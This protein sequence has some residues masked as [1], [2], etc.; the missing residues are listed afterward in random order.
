[1]SLFPQHSCKKRV[2]TSFF[3]LCL[4]MLFPFLSTANASAVDVDISLYSKA[5]FLAKSGRYKQAAEQYHRLSIMFLSSEAKLGRKNMWQYAGLAEGLA[6]IAADKSNSAKAYQYWADSMRY[7]M[8]GGT[9]WDQMKH[10]LHMRYEAANTQLSTQLQINDFAATI[11]EHWQN[12][13]D[14]LQ[15][16]D[17]KL[18]FFSFSSPKLG[19]VDRSQAGSTAVNASQVKPKVM[20]QPP[21]SSGKKLSGLNNSFSQSKQFAPV[22]AADPTPEPLSEPEPAE[23]NEPTLAE[24]LN[25]QKVAPPV[26]QNKVGGSQLAAS[27]TPAQDLEAPTVASRSDK[28][29]NEANSD[30]SETKNLQPKDNV[31]V[32]PIEAIS[33]EQHTATNDTPALKVSSQEAQT[34]PSP[35]NVPNPMAKGNLATIEEATVTPLQRRSFA[36][37]VSE[38]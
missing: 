18:D 6:A 33:F 35:P 32:L 11:D 17:E 27:M 31:V 16:W 38:E 10:K 4:L 15:A 36:P 7:L 13:L 24:D 2:V 29:I 30:Q 3:V 5:T 14:T 23:S 28:S 19:L 25:S 37:V 34:K 9:N 20:Y 1:M 21:S 26:Q 22:P 8:T 12:E